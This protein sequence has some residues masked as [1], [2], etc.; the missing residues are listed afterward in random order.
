M[1]TA[2]AETADA[3]A[4]E[5]VTETADGNVIEVTL[6]GELTAADYEAFL[7][8][9]E[10][11][12]DRY[13]TVR[14]VVILKDFRGWTVGALWEDVKFDA[15]HFA[16]VDRLAIV[17]DSAWEKGMTV[18]CKPFTTATVRYFDVSEVEAARDWVREG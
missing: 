12:L 2:F 15:K 11:L 8:R 6:S 4:T 9:T 1:P 13:E 7:P 16:D 5:T 3:R 14:M 10:T 18:F 17:G